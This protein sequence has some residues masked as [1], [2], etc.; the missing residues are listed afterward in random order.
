[1]DITDF[2]LG[3]IVIDKDG[4]ECTITNLTRN[5]IEVYIEKKTDQGVNCKQWFTLNDF[6]KRFVK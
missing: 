1:M 4:K 3:Q 6:E 2:G 5:S